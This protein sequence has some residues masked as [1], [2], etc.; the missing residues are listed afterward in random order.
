MIVLLKE[1]VV[2]DERVD[3]EGTISVLQALA[4]QQV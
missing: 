1:V 4:Q 3:R 2:I